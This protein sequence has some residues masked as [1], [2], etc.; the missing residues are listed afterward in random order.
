VKSTD[1]ASN[2]KKLRFASLARLDFD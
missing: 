2:D 1:K